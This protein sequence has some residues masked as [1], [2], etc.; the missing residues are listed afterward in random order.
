MLFLG[1]DAITSSEFYRELNIRNFLSRMFKNVKKTFVPMLWFA[2]EAYLSKE[3]ADQVK[4]IIILE[5]LGSVTCFGIGG[6]GIIIVFI[7]L[8]VFVRD[9][10]R[11]E[12]T[13]GL[14]ARTDNG[15]IS[16]N[17]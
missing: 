8:F 7:G 3:Y 1:E 16:I 15:E 9:N 10:F 6:I 14:L 2:Q 4:L 13:Q 5:S 17:G 11:G 12:E